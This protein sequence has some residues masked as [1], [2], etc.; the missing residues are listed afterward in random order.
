[1]KK[2]VQGIQVHFGGYCYL[3]H[4]SFSLFS[5]N[6][7]Y[8]LDKIFLNIKVLIIIVIPNF[9]YVLICRTIQIIEKIIIYNILS[10]A[11]LFLSFI[12]LTLW[13]SQCWP[14]SNITMACCCKSLT[15]KITYFSH[16]ISTVTVNAP[17]IFLSSKLLW[18]SIDI[19]IHAY[20]K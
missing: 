1:M 19:N 5:T 8:I 15:K 13:L 20:L 3:F 7:N 2:L 10:N 4:T 14:W 17:T 12:F 9:H 6:L 11:F 16:A 18:H